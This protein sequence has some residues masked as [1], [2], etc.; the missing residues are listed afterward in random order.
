[1]LHRHGLTDY[2]FN[3]ATGVVAT[4]FHMQGSGADVAS[5]LNGVCDS[6]W[7]LPLERLETEKAILRTEHASSSRGANESMPLWRYGAQDFG[8]VSYPEWGLYRVTPEDVQRWA[9]TWFTKQNAVL[10][11]AGD[12]VPAGLRLRLRDGVRR[13]LPAVSSALPQT[14]AYFAEGKGRV[15]FD[16]IV[17]RSAAAQVFAGVLERE[18]YRALRAEGGYSYTAATSYDP[19]GDAFATITAL[20][21]ALPDKQ[22]AVVGGFIDVLAKLRLGQIDAADIAAVKTKAGEAF[23]HPEL[24][25][26]R[27]PQCAINLLTGQ[28]N[29]SIDELRIELDAVTTE[30]VHEAAVE[31]TGSALLQVPAGHWADWAGFSE[32]PGMSSNSVSGKSFRSREQDDVRLVVAH[33]GVSMVSPRGAVTVYFAA[34]VAKFDWPDGARR[35]IGK[36][37]LVLHIEPT[38]FEVDA[39]AMAAIDAG[40]NS[41]AVV[42]FPARD[43]ESIPKPEPRKPEA[44]AKSKKAQAPSR[45]SGWETTAMV[46]LGLAAVVM[47]CV[48][49]SFT[50]VAAGDAERDV[51]SW[52]VVALAW[53]VGLPVFVPAFFLI[54]RRIRYRKAMAGAQ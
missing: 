48:G 37:G 1:V 33:D 5:F 9:E 34:C 21:D 46:L 19:R 53:G 39:Q 11:V 12:D 44:A 43:P 16:S 23:S 2:H 26:A 6:L 20:A 38:L 3:G 49:T 41:A 22:D 25:A 15:V 4:F 54:R 47:C 51:Y 31:A 45:I 8:L 10:W 50:A 29:L 13:P 24:S 14:P 7:D 18:L 35:L 36:D 52:V 28:P 40:V 30:S 32:A 27:L 17:R 42:P